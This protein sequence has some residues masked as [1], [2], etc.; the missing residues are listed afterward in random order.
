MLKILIS[1]LIAFN[2]ICFNGNKNLYPSSALEKVSI[3]TMPKS[4]FLNNIWLNGSNQISFWSPS[5]YKF[6]Q[7]YPFSLVSP[8]G[9]QL[10]NIVPQ[11]I[12]FLQPIIK[13]YLRT[14]LREKGI[15]KLV[16]IGIEESTNQKIELYGEFNLK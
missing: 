10:I 1:F 14:P 11:F 5:G 9:E 3:P 13:I 2:T 7:M 6:K 15:Y 16:L 4:I 12:D 8:S